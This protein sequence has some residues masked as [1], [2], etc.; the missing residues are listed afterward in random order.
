MTYYN[1]LLRLNI[2]TLFYKQRC[3]FLQNGW[4]EIFNANQNVDVFLFKLFNIQN[5]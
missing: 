3:L 2:E 1:I 4:N 5:L